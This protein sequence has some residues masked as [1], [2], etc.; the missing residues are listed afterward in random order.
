MVCYWQ[1]K[2]ALLGRVNKAIGG[3]R[4]RKVA[5]TSRLLP[6]GFLHKVV[7]VGI[8]H[9]GVENRKSGERS[10]RGGLWGLVGR[11][12]GK[13]KSDSCRSD[14]L[15]GQKFPRQKWDISILFSRT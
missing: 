5:F 14:P 15:I 4:G 11:L 12:S 3:V 2:V 7:N 13:K 1:Q 10:P 6:L 9:A 8:A